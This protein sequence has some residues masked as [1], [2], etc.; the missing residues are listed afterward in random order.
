MALLPITAWVPI[1]PP[2]LG[3][4]NRKQNDAAF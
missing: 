1:Y 4:V 3:E 2:R